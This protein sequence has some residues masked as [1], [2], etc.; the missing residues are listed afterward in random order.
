MFFRH[1]RDSLLKKKKIYK[2]TS[3][4]N[5]CKLRTCLELTMVTICQ[6]K[7][8][9]TI[10]CYINGT[11]CHGFPHHTWTRTEDRTS[12]WLKY[13]DKKYQHS[14]YGRTKLSL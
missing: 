14:P 2:H 13:Q 4:K 10:V 11:A 1:N 3:G 7:M 12:K 8:K 6:V 9:S 5:K